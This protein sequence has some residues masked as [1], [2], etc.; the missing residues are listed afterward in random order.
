[1]VVSALDAFEVIEGFEAV[2]APVQGLASGGTEFADP[3]GVM[4]AAMRADNDLLLTQQTA[5]AGGALRGR[6]AK[7]AQLFFP[8][9]GNPVGGPGRGQD[10]PDVRIADAA[11]RRASA[12]NS[13][14]SS[15]AG[16]PE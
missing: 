5:F 1:M 3:L 8:F 2:L 7:C 16:Q 11:A 15:V 6:D 10:A 13:S 9:G 4:A 12:I 14:I